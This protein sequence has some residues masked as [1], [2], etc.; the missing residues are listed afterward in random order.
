MLNQSKTAQSKM[1]CRQMA[2]PLQTISSVGLVPL[3]SKCWIVCKKAVAVV[4]LAVK[5]SDK[6]TVAN[7]FGLASQAI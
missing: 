1:P 5:L 6:P 3:D 4:K 2:Q 7:L